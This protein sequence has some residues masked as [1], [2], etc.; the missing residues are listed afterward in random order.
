MIADFLDAFD[1]H[2]IPVRRFAAT[3]PARAA[4]VIAHG[5]AEHGGRYS[6]LA[7]FLAARGC[8]VCIVDHRGHGLSIARPED[9]GHFADPAAHIDG[10]QRVV[11]DL[12][13][14]I[15]HQRARF[16][17]LPLV[18]LGHSMGSFIAQAVTIAHGRDIDMLVL[19]GSNHDE[20]RK[21]R[22][23]RLLA[24]LETLR[25]GGRGKSPLLAFL[26]FGAFN[27]PFAPVRTEYDWLSRDQTEV[28]RYIADPL[29]GFAVT[30]Q[31]WVDLLG[32]LI[33]IS[34]VKNLANMP[35]NLPVYLFGGDRDPVGRFGKGLPQLE[36]MLRTAG[37]RN[38]TLKLYR[39]GRHEMLNEIN[40]DEVFADLAAW[41]DKTMTRRPL[42]ERL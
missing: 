3:T 14:V 39:D 17:N 35:H 15:S 8:E 16:P 28:D 5:M 42:P 21:Y 20:L 32:G 11:D 29:C 18:L 31:L 19:S 12:H 40:R 1:G 7:E 26:S 22:A 36:R 30:N 33:R 4:V 13:H 6:P 41:L 37:L 23:A 34:T 24:R 38:I 2:R 25:Q 27:K 10:W 9:T